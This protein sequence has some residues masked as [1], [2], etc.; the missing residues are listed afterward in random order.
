[1]RNA[2]GRLPAGKRPFLSIKEVIIMNPNELLAVL[3]TVER[4]KD[5][6]RHCYTSQRSG[7]QLAGHADG[8]PDAG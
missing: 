5:T 8:F 3:H 4:L 1:M 6:T 2:K 7:A